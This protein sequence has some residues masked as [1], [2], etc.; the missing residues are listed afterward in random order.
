METVTEIFS[1]ICGQGRCFAAGAA[2]LPLCQRCLGLYMGAAL[3]ASWLTASGA[4]RSGLP[5]RGIIIADSAALAAAL[6]GGLHVLDF[7]PAWRTACGAWT[8]HV[9]VFWLSCAAAAAWPHFRVPWPRLRGHE[10]QNIQAALALA[11]VTAV[12]LAIEHLL[13]L[14]W[15]FWTAVAAFGMMFCLAAAALAAAALVRRLI[16]AAPAAA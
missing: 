2:E 5:G 8:G 7:G 9:A 10:T 15:R 4:W 12:A 3:T 13:P 6:L 11:A 1:L 14:G 16:P